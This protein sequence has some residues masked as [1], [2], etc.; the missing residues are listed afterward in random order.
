MWG[1]AMKVIQRWLPNT[2]F[3][4]PN[5]QDINGVLTTVPDVA[6]LPYSQAAQQLKQAGYSVAD[7]GYR[8][9][10]YA[11]DTVAY[12]SPAAGT[13]APSGSTITIYRSDGTPYVPPKRHHNG[14]NG[15]PGNGHGHH[16]H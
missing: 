14:G 9:S 4:T 5:G 11:K 3:V 7:G 6:G 12:T 1:D 10:S 13:Q 8:D 15:G 16:G 2:D